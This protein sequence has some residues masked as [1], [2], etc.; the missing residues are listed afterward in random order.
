MPGHK[1]EQYYCGFASLEAL[2]DWFCPGARHM[3]ASHGFRVSVFDV[4]KQL[5]IE[6]DRQCVFWRDRSRRVGTLAV[7][8]M[9]PKSQPKQEQEETACVC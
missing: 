7:D 6:G 4:P 2:R 3:L 9:A 1:R 8:M 5:V